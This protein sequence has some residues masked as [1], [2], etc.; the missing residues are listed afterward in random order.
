MLT[1]K[2][3][4]MNIFRKNVKYMLKHAEAAINIKYAT[5]KGLSLFD[6][7]L[8]YNFTHG[9]NIIISLIV[10]LFLNCVKIQFRDWIFN[11]PEITI[12]KLLT[13]CYFCAFCNFIL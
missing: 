7:D 10:F 4:C 1:D 13:N 12:T 11:Y 2:Y 5:I 3:F 8:N 6:A 9:N